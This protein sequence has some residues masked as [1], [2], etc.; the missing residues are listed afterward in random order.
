M[1]ENGYS[2][3]KIEEIAKFLLCKTKHRPTVGIICGSGLSGLADTM[4]DPSVFPY[5]DIPDFPISTVPGHPGR[6][7]FGI[8]K[9]TPVV[10]MQ[11]R[12]HNYEG[13]TL[14]KCAMPIRVMKLIGVK[15][16]ILTNAAGGINENYNVGDIMIVKDHINM[17]GFA[18]DSPLRGKNDER[19]GPRFPGMT[20]LYDPKLRTI[21]KAV[22]K[23][24]GLGNVVREGVYVMVGGPSYETVA[25]LKLLR[26]VGADAVGMSTVHEAITAAHCGLQVFALSLITN[27]CILEYDTGSEA[28]HKEVLETSEK[29]KVDLQ[30]FVSELVIEII[31]QQS[32]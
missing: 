17:P 22:A 15:T 28:N 19:W 4:E 21:A 6:L 12:F 31:K 23:N 32:N 14:W 2:F 11:G 1:E 18:G 3:E 26:L 30:L 7:V 16:V 5:G 10:C 27:K 29:R 20:N 24:T 25:E 13:Y 9:G 8:L